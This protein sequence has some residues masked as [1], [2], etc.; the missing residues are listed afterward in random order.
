DKVEG[1][2]ATYEGVYENAEQGK[3]RFQL[4]T[5]NVS[6]QQTDKK[7]P[8]ATCEVTLPP[9]EL[10]NVRMNQRE[11][12]EVAAATGGVFYTAATADELPKDLPDG[13]R[14]ELK[15]PTDPAILWNH[16]LIFGVVLFL[17]GSEWILRKRKHLL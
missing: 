1:S 2:W 6:E 8:S 14:M 16:F 13:P 5:P 7:N 4:L 3:Y 17:L 9:T 15:T 10:E 11:L 12:K